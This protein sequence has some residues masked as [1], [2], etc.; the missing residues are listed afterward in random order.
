MTIDPLELF[1]WTFRRN[2]KDVV[3]L[4][5]S[6]SDVMRLAT[7]G[8][9]LNFGYWTENTK[10][11]IDAQNE[12]CKIFGEFSD[13]KSATN[14]I[15]IGSGFSAP[16][17]I[18]KTQFSPLE[19]TC[20]NIN[21]NQLKQSSSRINES[22]NSIDGINLLNS[23]STSLPFP[24]ESVDRILA[25]ES[26]QHVKHLENFIS[27]S[28]R[29]LKK[30]GILAIAIPIVT[31]KITPIVDLGILSMTWY[32]EHYTTDYIKLLLIDNGFKILELQNIGSM[33][34]GPLT[35]YYIRNRDDVKNKILSK[36]PSYVEK[37]LFKSLQKMKQLSEKN[38]ID[39]VL[40]KCEN[41]R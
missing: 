10:E 30:H 26:L 6:F 16:A 36:Y 32:S 35:N 40:I 2:E 38:V 27:E 21:F 7:G 9:M 13:L 4:Y 15:D 18:W 19:I 24:N 3:N 8:D 25:L 34:Y 37:I 5:D 17:I 33:V 14:I 1:L 11:P 28:K 29:I 39:Y 31:K 20:V 22:E 41:T 23:T 12:L